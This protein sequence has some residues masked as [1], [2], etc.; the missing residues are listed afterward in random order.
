MGY[1]E[2]DVPETKALAD[3]LLAPL[4]AGDIGPA[5]KARAAMAVPVEPPSLRV[6]RRRGPHVPLSRRAPWCA[7]VCLQ[8]YSA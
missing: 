4:A 7:E 5:P 6:P 8:G 2:D 3:K 1:V